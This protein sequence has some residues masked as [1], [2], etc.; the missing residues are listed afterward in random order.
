MWRLLDPEFNLINSKE[1]LDRVVCVK[2]GSEEISIQRFSR[3]EL[4]IQKMSLV[5]DD[6]FESVG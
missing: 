1:L 2:S 6:P 3:L 4:V 5:I